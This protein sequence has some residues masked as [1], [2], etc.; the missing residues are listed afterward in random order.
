MSTGKKIHLP[1]FSFYNQADQSEYYIY[2]YIPFF[3]LLLLV[4]AMSDQL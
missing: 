1:V 2:M 4:I 3:I